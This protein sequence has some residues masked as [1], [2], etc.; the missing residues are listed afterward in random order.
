MPWARPRLPRE[1]RGLVSRSIT[2]QGGSRQAGAA[3]GGGGSRRFGCGRD[4]RRIKPYGSH[5]SLYG[6]DPQA[7]NWLSEMLSCPSVER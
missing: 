5:S 4:A 3:I 1:R 2:G 7:G 6:L